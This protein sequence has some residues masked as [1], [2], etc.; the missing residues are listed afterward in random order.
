M[1]RSFPSKKRKRICCVCGGLDAPYKF[2]CCGSFFCSV[3]CHKQHSEEQTCNKVIE[4]VEVSHG[5]EIPREDFVVGEDE[6][7]ITE[8]ELCAIG[9]DQTLMSMLQNE[10][11]QRIIRNIDQSYNPA[12]SLARRMNMDNDFMEVIDHI[13][14]CLE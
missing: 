10:K 12:A 2:K 5:E 3:K 9:R 14:R 7:Q 4:T 1:K 6:I 13:S 11:L 8:K